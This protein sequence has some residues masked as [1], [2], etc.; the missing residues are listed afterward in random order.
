MFDSRLLFYL[1]FNSAKLRARQKERLAQRNAIEESHP[2][3]GLPVESLP[4]CPTNPAKDGD[5]ATGLVQFFRERPSVI[6]LED[7]KLDAPKAKTDSPLRLGRQSKHK[8]SRLDLSV[9][10]LD[11]LSPD[12]FFPSHQS[13][14]TSM[15]NSV[16][17]NNLLPVLGLCAPNASQIE[18]SNKNFSRSNCRQKG[19]RPEFPFSLAPQSGTL[20]ETDVNGDEVKL[21]GASAEV[22][23][24]KNNI[25]NGGLPFRPVLSLS[26]SLFRFISFVDTCVLV[27]KFC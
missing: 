23:R 20:S 24:L 21:S 22:S 3:E 2:S 13:Q 16:P 9:N 26:L 4:P 7:N 10:P 25:P 6:D 19:A 15:T 1:L 27:Y 14:R 11:Y 18:S 8:S 12:I 17:P 5:Q